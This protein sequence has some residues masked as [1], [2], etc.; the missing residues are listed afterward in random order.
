VWIGDRELTGDELA[1][2][3][4]TAYGRFINDTYW[5]LMPW[6]W[7]D[8]GVHLTAQG[9]AEV[10]GAACD[11]VELTFGDVGLT[12]G[13][14]YL[15]YVDRGTGLMRRWSYVLQ[16]EDGTPGSAEPTVWNWEG[17]RRV[18][19]GVWFAERKVR[20]GDGPPTAIVTDGIE[21]YQAPTDEQLASWFRVP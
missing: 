19:P 21:L 7:L 16:E 11:V 17:W 12:S 15:G 6:K 8:P 3:L 9:T 14:R 2:S 5:L 1:Q 4:E 20:Q 18:E 13:D 10:D